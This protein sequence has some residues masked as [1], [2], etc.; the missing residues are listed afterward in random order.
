MF[1]RD[2]CAEPV[3]TDSLS[4]EVTN[5]FRFG[6]QTY[7]PGQRVWLPAPKAR[8]LIKAGYGKDPR[9]TP[10]RTPPRPVR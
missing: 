10:T 4:I 6:D 1:T 2:T 5:S 9:N 3:F 8:A 7:T